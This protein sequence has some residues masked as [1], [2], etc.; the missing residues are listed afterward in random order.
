MKSPRNTTVHLNIMAGD[1]AVLQYHNNHDGKSER[2]FL[3]VTKKN[4]SVSLQTD[5]NRK[6]AAT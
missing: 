5:P 3:V 2:F 6:P 4:L 1:Y